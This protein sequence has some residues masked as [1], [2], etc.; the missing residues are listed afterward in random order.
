[1]RFRWKI[2]FAIVAVA[3]VTAIS[4]LL[5]QRSV[6]RQQ[7]TELI[8]GQMRAAVIEAENVRSSIA[9][10]R[11]AGVTCPFFLYQS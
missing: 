7:G 4:G 5:V 9:A 11:N 10:L 3:A 8:L 6:I 2:T 1:M